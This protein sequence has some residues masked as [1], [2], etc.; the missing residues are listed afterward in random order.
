M[1][2][3]KV[4]SNSN[5][6]SKLPIWSSITAALALDYWNAP[7][8]MI[9]A[10]GL[11]FIVTWILMIIDMAT[12]EKVDV[13]EEVKNKTAKNSK[14]QDKLKEAMDASDKARA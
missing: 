5:L 4:I 2:T 14:F 6:P 7:E 3:N 11:F 8:W 10:V 13:F 12:Q 9:G 1:T